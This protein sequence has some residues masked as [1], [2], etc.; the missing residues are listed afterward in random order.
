MC[1]LRYIVLTLSVLIASFG[2]ME[3]MKSE[4]GLSSSDESSEKRVL[5]RQ[6]SRLEMVNERILSILSL[7]FLSSD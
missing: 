4:K 7:K 2:I 3:A 1:P 5:K 6:P